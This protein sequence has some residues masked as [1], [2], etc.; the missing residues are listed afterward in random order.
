MDPNK[1]GSAHIFR[2]SISALNSG[3]PCLIVNS[4]LHVVVIFL[5]KCNCCAGFMAKLLPHRGRRDNGET[6]VTSAV[7]H[8]S[9]SNVLVGG[10]TLL[11]SC[12]VAR[13]SPLGRDG[14]RKF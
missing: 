1:R 11:F 13:I 2:T 8:A 3:C 7:T 6:V 4:F 9:S 10:D 12:L 14:E 5:R